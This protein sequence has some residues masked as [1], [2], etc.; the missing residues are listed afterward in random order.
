M[1]RMDVYAHLLAPGDTAT[2]MVTGRLTTA[3]V[4]FGR[5]E[6]VPMRLPG[7]RRADLLLPSQEGVRLLAGDLT[8][9]LVDALQD[10]IEHLGKGD[11]E[12]VAPETLDRLDRY[13]RALDALRG[14]FIDDEK[15]AGDCL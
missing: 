13:E 7:G 10:A 15:L 5:D 1:A 9:T 6:L 2:V 3:P 8:P 14:E 11:P 12:W 4:R